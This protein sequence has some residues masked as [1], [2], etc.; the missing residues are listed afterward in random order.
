MTEA[1]KRIL[2]QPMDL[3]SA[4]E[5]FQARFWSK[6]DMRGADDCWP[7]TAYRKPSGYGQFTVRKGVFMTASRVALALTVGRPLGLGE[8]ACHHCD[9]PPCCNPAH[10]FA[11][12]VVANAQDSIDKGRFRR[13]VGIDAGSAKLSEEQVKAIRAELER[14]GTC[15]GLGR[16]YGVSATTIRK[17]RDGEHWRHL[18]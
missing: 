15:K 7:W 10:L 8:L 1:T 4:D 12:D 3:T 11:G 6:V 13:A 9:N 16:V 5:A 18:L 17:I 14:G 2:G